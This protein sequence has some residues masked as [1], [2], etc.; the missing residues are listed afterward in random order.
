M[1]A[2]VRRTYDCCKAGRSA[3]RSG[4]IGRIMP[5]ATTNAVTGRYGRP[6]CRRQRQ[7]HQPAQHLPIL[8]VAWSGLVWSLNH[9]AQTGVAPSPCFPSVRRNRAAGAAGIASTRSATGRGIHPCEPSGMMHGTTAAG[10]GWSARKRSAASNVVGAVTLPTRGRR[11]GGRRL[12]LLT[13]ASG[14]SASALT[15]RLRVRHDVRRGAGAR[16]RCAVQ[17]R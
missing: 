8:G 7:L 11:R 13:G 16:Q 12:R 1:G 4:P 9:A 6:L 14:H 2:K 10:S 17:R 3:N 15:C 5:A